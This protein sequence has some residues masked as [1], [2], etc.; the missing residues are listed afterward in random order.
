MGVSHACIRRDEEKRERGETFSS[1]LWGGLS[2]CWLLWKGPAV[3]EPVCQSEWATS[4]W[5]HPL[6][7]STHA[8]THTHIFKLMRIHASAHR[9][10]HTLTQR[11]FAFFL[12][13]PQ[14]LLQWLTCSLIQPSTDSGTMVTAA[15]MFFPQE[16]DNIE[17]TTPL[18][19]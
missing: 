2:Q 4:A 3:K 14:S 6:C 9:D 15:E 8:C 17:I 16:T 12:S 11:M 10:T 18:T 13:P 7:Q 19:T 1:K 5:E